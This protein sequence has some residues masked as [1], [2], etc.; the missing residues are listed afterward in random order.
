MAQPDTTAKAA[1]PNAHSAEK[2][3]KAAT[4]TF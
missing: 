4:R 1:I 3:Q 2:K